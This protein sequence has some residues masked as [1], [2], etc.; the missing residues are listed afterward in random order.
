MGLCAI[1][2]SQTNVSGNISSD[3]TWNFAGSPYVVTGNLTVDATFTLTIDA[4][5]EV[6]FDNGRSMY[7]NGAVNATNTTFTS[8]TGT[9]PG[10]WNY[11]QFNAGS[12]SILTNCQ[13]EYGQYVNVGA[14]GDLTITGGAIENMYYYGIYTAGIV[15]ISNAIIDLAGYISTGHGIYTHG[16]SVTSIS[17][18]KPF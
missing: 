13:V 7:V 15:N 6:R 3:S 5:V 16:S 8:N 12:V 17:N 11:L 18:T 14:G 4:G 9:T 2:Y 10:L 1:T